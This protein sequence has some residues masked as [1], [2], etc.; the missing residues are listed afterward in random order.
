MRE[1]GSFLDFPC[2]FFQPVN[3]VVSTGTLQLYVFLFNLA[4]L[5]HQFQNVFSYHVS[6]LTVNFWHDFRELFEVA[7][8]R[9]ET[10]RLRSLLLLGTHSAFESGDFIFDLHLF[11]ARNV[12]IFGLSLPDWNFFQ[13]TPL[14]LVKGRARSAHHLA[15]FCPDEILEEFDEV[16]RVI[17]DLLLV[18]ESTFFRGLTR[19]QVWVLV[20]K[21]DLKGC[22]ELN[23]QSSVY[24]GA[25][26]DWVDDCK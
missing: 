26:L 10:L 17:Q 22:D 13:R 9:S 5:C 8:D 6:L 19:L 14:I 4:V 21:C 1:R 20:Q 25:P 2:E 7:L 23:T 18:L 16:V 15:G 11:R 12:L 24:L 3:E